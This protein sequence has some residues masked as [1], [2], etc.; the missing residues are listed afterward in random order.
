MQL[1]HPSQMATPAMGSKL[2]TSMF[3]RMSASVTV[4]GFANSAFCASL[5]SA[6]I[7]ALLGSTKQI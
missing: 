7:A 2:P 1:Q 3:I 6:L 4:P 5:T